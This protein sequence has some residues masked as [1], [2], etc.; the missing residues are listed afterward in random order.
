M[1][2]QSK[3][4]LLAIADAI[5]LLRTFRGPDLTRTIGQ[6]EKSL[7]GAT[8]DGYAAVFDDQWGEGRHSPRRWFS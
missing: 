8:A 2:E 3:P 7:K 5:H 1:A 4:T 6:I